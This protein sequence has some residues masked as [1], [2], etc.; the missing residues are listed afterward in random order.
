MNWKPTTTKIILSPIVAF[1][2]VWYV[3]IAGFCREDY[4]MTYMFYYFNAWQ[5]SQVVLWSVLL[6]AVFTA[7]VYSIYSL[8]Q[9]ER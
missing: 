8:I 1:F 7:I 9:K 3:N 6:F 4:C 5:G 2:I